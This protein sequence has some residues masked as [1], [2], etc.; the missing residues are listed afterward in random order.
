MEC[1]DKFIETVG[2]YIDQ[3][4]EIIGKLSFYMREDFPNNDLFEPARHRFQRGVMNGIENSCKDVKRLYKEYK[5][6]T[7]ARGIIIVAIIFIN[8]KYFKIPI[9]RCIASVYNSIAASYNPKLAFGVL[10]QLLDSK[11]KICGWFF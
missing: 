1:A 6:C 3:M 10:P 5:N 11:M 9:C 7:N 2:Y 8:K 4:H